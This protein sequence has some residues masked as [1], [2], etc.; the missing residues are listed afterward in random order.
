MLRVVLDG[1]EVLQAGHPD[2]ARAAARVEDLADP[3]FREGAARLHQAL[4][5]FRAAHG[6]GRAIAAVQIGVPLRLVA[7]NLG[8]GPVTLVNPRIT[9]RSPETFTLWDDCMSFPDRLVRVRRHASIDLEFL[10]GEGR[11]NEWR[12][13]DRAR[14]ELF[15]HELDHLDGVLALDRAEGPDA[16]IARAAYEADPEGFDARVDYRIEPTL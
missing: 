15:Q 11:R 3:V 12:D 2:L 1:I 5:A 14:S 8:E 13:L 4:A 10:D 6:F 16:V 7:A 9:R